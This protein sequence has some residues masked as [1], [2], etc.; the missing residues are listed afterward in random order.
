VNIE[1]PGGAETW[2]R[3]NVSPGQVV[4]FG[5]SGGDLPREAHDRLFYVIGTE[6]IDAH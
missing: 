6:I 1:L 5:G 2:T 4:V 3:L